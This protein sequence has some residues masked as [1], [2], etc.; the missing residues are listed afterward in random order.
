MMY[1]GVAAGMGAIDAGGVR[2]LA[3]TGDKRS[4]ALP[5][6]PTFKEAG[7]PEFD[8]ASW[9]VLLA[10]KGTPAPILSLLRNE[11]L[12]ALR[13]PA[14]REALSRLGIEVSERQDVRAF[15]TEESVKFGRVVLE[16]GI[17]LGQ[18]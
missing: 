16:L 8:F 4:S 14:F 12:D 5:N 15:L 2:A 1:A 17:T 10:A 7:V 11:T 13:D 18:Q 3:V 9:S 6:V